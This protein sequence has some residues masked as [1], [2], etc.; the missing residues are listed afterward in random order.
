MKPRKNKQ[1]KKLNSK[2]GKKQNLSR[3]LNGALTLYRSGKLKLALGKCQS[4]LV[5]HPRHSDAFNLAGI[6]HMD[7]GQTQQSVNSM[8][9]VVEI[10]PA[11]SKAHFNLGTALTANGELSEAISSQRRALE[12]KPDYADALFN[13]GNAYRQSGDSKAAI[14][15]YR[16]ALDLE[17]DYPGAATNLASSLLHLGRPQDALDACHEALK[18]YPGDRD[19]L[20]FKAIAATEVGDPDLAASILGMDRVIRTK[21]FDAADGFRDMAEFNKALVA[22]VLSHPTLTREPHNVATRNGQQTE[23]LALEPKGPIAQLEAMIIATYDEYMSVLSKESGHP[24]IRLIPD[25]RKIDIWGTVLD[26]MG[27]QAAHMHRNAWISGVYY[28][29]LPDV[30]HGANESR[31]GWIE[32]GRPPDEFPCAVEHEVRNFEPR[33]GRMFMFPSFEYHRTIPFESSEQ[34]IS[35]AFDLLARD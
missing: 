12:L 28:V 35:I 31:S 32:F 25:L 7:L 22:H 13:L 33:E 2:P 18:H 8:R 10:H 26:R 14:L 5:N 6:I 24:Y 19:A 1:R 20:A 30:M 4:V 16:S 11:S 15:S 34:R 27:H 9:S 17:F 29:Q 3:V 21:D 23:N